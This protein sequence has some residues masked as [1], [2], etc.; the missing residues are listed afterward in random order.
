MCFFPDDYAQ[1]PEMKKKPLKRYQIQN[2]PHGNRPGVLILMF[3]AQPFPPLN[4]CRCICPG[5]LSVCA[6]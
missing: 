2:V 6:C 4:R 5:E 1:F 3:G